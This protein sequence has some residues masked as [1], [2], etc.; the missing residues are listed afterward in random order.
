LK[1]AVT[2]DLLF[3]TMDDHSFYYCIFT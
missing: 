3:Q 2:N 1:V